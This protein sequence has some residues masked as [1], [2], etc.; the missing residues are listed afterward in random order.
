MEMEIKQFS[1]E[2]DKLTEKL[3][4]DDAIIE[5]QRIEKEKLLKTLKTLEESASKAQQECNALSL[6]Y[7]CIQEQHA[8]IEAERKNLSKMPENVLAQQMIRDEL[9]KDISELKDELR[10]HKPESQHI[11]PKVIS[12]YENLNAKIKSFFFLIAVHTRKRAVARRTAV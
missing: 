9:V 2:K 3:A 11:H 6:K 10:K 5:G 12:Q 8:E 7:S 1:D 4:N